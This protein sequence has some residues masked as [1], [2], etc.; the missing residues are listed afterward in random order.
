VFALIAAILFGTTGT[1][2]AL[3]PEGASSLSV[4][5]ARI[6]LGSAGLALVAWILSRRKRRALRDP[7]P[8]HPITDMITL[9]IPAL[10]GPE[11]QPKFRVSG[12]T[13]KFS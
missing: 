9:H 10:P 13:K 12:R 4:G 1:A 8:G 7:R 2:Q 6:V 11:R 5:A 3:G